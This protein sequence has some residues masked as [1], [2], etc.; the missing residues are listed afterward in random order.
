MSD[1]RARYRLDG[2]AIS[3]TAHR[4][5]NR[6]AERFP[7]SGLAKVTRHLEGVGRKAHE[8]T[9][10]LAAPNWPLRVAMA[11]AILF[12]TGLLVVTGRHLEVAD[13][14]LNRLSPFVQLIES[15]SSALFF[16]GATL[17]F[18]WTFEGRL[19]RRRALA[20][21]HELRS[22]AHVIDMHQLTKDPE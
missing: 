2:D 19:K 15:A 3:E 5:A 13:E 7:D 17:I 6:I 18:L 9:L 22:L 11:A 4:L 16:L 12:V 21:V 14:T 20:A 10:A 8:T 1:A